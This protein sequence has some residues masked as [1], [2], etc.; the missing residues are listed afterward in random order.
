MR[1]AGVA[2]PRL[3]D[4]EAATAA[5]ATITR[6]TPLIPSR[7]LTE[8]AGAPVL[9][10]AEVLQRTGSFKVRGAA[11]FLAGL[12]EA[13]RRRGVIAASAGNHAQGVA[14]AA[15][16]FGAPCHV[17]MPEGTAI[18]KERAT[19]DY[20]AV[21]HVEGADLSEAVARA[22]ELAS[23]H[24]WT[25][26]P[27]YDDPRI[28]AGQGTLGLELFAQAPD[29]GCVIV[30]VGGGGLAAGVALALKSRNPAIRVIGVQAA[31]MDSAVRSFHAAGPVRVPVAPT[32][33]DGC[34]VP[35]VGDLTLTLLNRYV[36]EMTAVSEEWI[37]TAMVW[38]L[39]RSKLVVE[40]AGALGVAALLAGATDVQGRRTAVIL[41]GGNI[42]INSVARSLEHGLAR[43]GRYLTLVVTLPDRPGQLARLL[44]TAA[45]AEANVL[46]VWHRRSAPTL[47]VGAVEIELLLEI[48]DLD[49]A[50]AITSALTETGLATVEQRV[51]LLRLRHPT[52]G[53]AS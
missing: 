6:E 14:V 8:L 53:E 9:L 51:G 26:V 3:E 40:G 23:E 2:P 15:A 34:A 35:R 44:Q 7:R 13:E 27:P 46:D 31:A 30:P 38:L 16:A 1:D 39:E 37:S 28:V 22:E 24:G 11:A 45:A 48:R 21:V 50:A 47:P 42:D 18:P 5:V 12:G 52:V 10:K 43:A 49:H 19:R 4:I 33:A 36:D 41:S 17:V 29:L 32:L 25:F 20:G